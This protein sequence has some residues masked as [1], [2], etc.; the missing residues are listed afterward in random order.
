MTCEFDKDPVG[1][2]LEYASLTQQGSQDQWAAWERANIKQR[3]TGVPPILWLEPY[4]TKDVLAEALGAGRDVDKVKATLEAIFLKLEL[5]E[6]IT[7][8]IFQYQGGGNA[9]V[10]AK[11]LSR[12][13]RDIFRA[14]AYREHLF[15]LPF[16]ARRWS[17]S[18]VKIYN[19]GDRGIGTGFLVDERY[20]AT[21]R[22]VVDDLPSDFE[23]EL[24]SGQSSEHMTSQTPRRLERMAIH[25]PQQADL[26]IALVELRDPVTDVKP[27]RI[28]KNWGLLEEVVVLGYP[29]VPHARDAY[30]LANRGEVSSTIH[31]RSGLE[32]MLISC[33]LRGGNSGGPVLNQWG[34]VIGVVSQNLVE[35]MAPGE[36][37]FTQGLGFAAAFSAQ[38]IKDMLE[39]RGKTIPYARQ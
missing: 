24:E 6:L 37:D 21:A 22:H 13:G 19:P 1:A 3:K 8:F 35:L 32:A 7:P 5:K 30:L 36:V 15:G 11:Q 20:I 38:W 26:D 2:V 25:V 28:E 31:L 10:Q 29:P 34:H 9:H 12:F 16:V 33:L 14:D 18:V 27:I 39:A 17:R 4:M 23:I